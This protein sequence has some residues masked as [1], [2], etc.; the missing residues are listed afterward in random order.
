MFSCFFV[1]SLCDKQLRR[2]ILVK[3][4][5]APINDIEDYLEFL[6]RF[7]APLPKGKDFEIRVHAWNPPAI[8][9]NSFQTYKKSAR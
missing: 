3:H 1:L 4:Y 6:S 7:I 2:K 5:G 8:N 9:W